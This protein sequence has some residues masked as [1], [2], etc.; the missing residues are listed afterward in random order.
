MPVERGVKRYTSCDVRTAGWLLP[1][2]YRFTEPHRADDTL[3]RLGVDAQ[4]I[5]VDYGLTGTNRDRPGLREELAA[6][7]EGDMLVVSK[8]DRL[9]RSVPDARAIADELTGRKV[10]LDIGGSV[11]HPPTRSDGCCSPRCR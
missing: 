6:V 8:L 7:R 3:T 1:P 2:Q 9:A 10:K 5:Y 4:R 11:Y